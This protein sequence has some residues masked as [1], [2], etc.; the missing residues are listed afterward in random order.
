MSALFNSFSGDPIYL[1]KTA[2]VKNEVPLKQM[3]AEDAIHCPMCNNI[4][5][6]PVKLPCTHVFCLACIRQLA[7]STS[8]NT[9]PSPLCLKEVFTPGDRLE[10][11]PRLVEI[12]K[13]Q[14][15]SSNENLCDEC[16]DARKEEQAVIYCNVCEQQLCEDCHERH[17]RQKILKSH[18]YSP[19][20]S[21]QHRVESFTQQMTC[22]KH[23]T[24]QVMLYCKNC[25]MT[26][27]TVCKF[28]KNEAHLLHDCSLIS[29]IAGEYRKR[30]E[31]GLEGVR[32]ISCM[33]TKI[34]ENHMK[35]FKE[36]KWHQQA[37]N[38]CKKQLAIVS[39]IGTR[40]LFMEK[41][42]IEKYLSAV[43]QFSSDSQALQKSG[44]D[45]EIVQEFDA[46]KEKADELKEA[47]E[48]LSTRPV[49]TVKDSLTNAELW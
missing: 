8:E 27:C 21:R 32:S 35:L 46:L 23:P 40:N 19:L 12:S 37:I 24:Q 18:T 15:T 34:T 9:S 41:M 13:T 49:P 47:R 22:D 11:L 36:L 43:Q 33:T 38:R 45:I 42:E 31:E 10:S 5:S 2:S 48:L 17:K 4:F 1:G 20:G 3:K 25:R 28:D 29:D 16:K 26:L 6:D 7:K 44:S 30:L 39:T 14:E